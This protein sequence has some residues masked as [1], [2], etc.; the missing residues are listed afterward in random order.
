MPNPQIREH[1]RLRHLHSR[2]LFTLNSWKNVFVGQHQQEIPEV[3]RRSAQPILKTEHEASRVL[4][5]LH[6]QVFENSR[7]RVEELEHGVLK[8]SSAGFFPLFHE[9]GNGALALPKLR[10][11]KGAELVQAHHLRHR[12]KH[13][14]RFETVA[15]GGHCL[16]DLLR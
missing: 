6:W 7:K 12:R 2:T 8:A 10:H 3:V 16:D 5:L 14:S 1:L 11:R 13:H 4:C 15:V 9:A